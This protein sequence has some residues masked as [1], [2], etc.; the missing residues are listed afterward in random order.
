MFLKVVATCVRTQL[1]IASE[2][3]S[4]ADA[5]EGCPIDFGANTM[6]RIDRRNMVG[7]VLVGA[8]LAVS[9]LALASTARA[10]GAVG[11]FVPPETETLA[12]KAQVVVVGP[13]RRRGRRWRCW[14]RRGRRVCG[15]RW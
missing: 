11:S 4:Q 14:W 12:E 6:T 7:L 10:V 2:R 5:Q 8:G 1:V 13:R 15:W 3:W 9:G